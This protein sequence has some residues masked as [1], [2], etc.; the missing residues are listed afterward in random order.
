MND[1]QSA[2]KEIK[3]HRKEIKTGRKEIKAPEMEFQAPGG[4]NSKSVVYNFQR[5][6]CESGELAKTRS[7]SR[8]LQGR[9]APPG[10]LARAGSPASRARAGLQAGRETAQ[11]CE[12]SFPRGVVV[13]GFRRS[14]LMVAIESLEHLQVRPDRAEVARVDR[15]GGEGLRALEPDELKQRM[16]RG[17]IDR[18]PPHGVADD[19]SRRSLTRSSRAISA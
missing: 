13:H 15:L 12:Q 17:V 10:G 3:T 18:L 2:T 9:A 4:R 6:T 5:L 1:F 11:L 14:G 7:A 19:P 8:P 16:I